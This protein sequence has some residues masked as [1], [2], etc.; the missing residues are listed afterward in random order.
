MPL[1]EAAQ[2]KNMPNS[3][4]L[5]FLLVTPPKTHMEPE[6]AP[7]EEEIWIRFFEPSGSTVPS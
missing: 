4:V 7:L 6:N 2:Q 5:G 3:T 1:E